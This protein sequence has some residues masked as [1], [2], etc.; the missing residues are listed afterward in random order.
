MSPEIES[1]TIIHPLGFS[2]KDVF[3]SIVEGKS[4][5]K[6]LR[7]DFLEHPVYA[8][9]FSEE[10][11][12]RLKMLC[13]FEGWNRFERLIWSAGKEVLEKSGISFNDKVLVIV[14][15]TKGGIEEIETNPSAANLN[16]HLSV[17][18]VIDKLSTEYG[19]IAGKKP[20]F[21]IVSN[22]CVSGLSAMIAGKRFLEAQDY[23][24]AVI[25][26]ADTV[27]DFVL[28]GFNSLF[29]LSDQLCRPFDKARNGI[30]LG[31]GAAAVV[32]RRNSD[33]HFNHN[34]IYLTGGA[35]TNDANHISGP[36]RTGEELAE[37]IKKAVNEADSNTFDF[38][39]AHGTATIYND[40]MESKAF[41]EAGVS[42]IPVH[43]LKQYAGHTLGAAGVME[44]VICIESLVNN[45]LIPSLGYSDCG[46][47]SKLN[48][49][50]K[51]ENREMTRF[52]KTM[53]GFG[54]CNAAVCF[55]KR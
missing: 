47:S 14:A 9:Y 26:G 36:S 32:L 31:E 39:S 44:S 20:P 54:G 28:S 16:I 55:E 15:T 30:N 41:A 5:L 34:K 35:T 51:L 13:P 53:S 29:A 22:A 40:E 48:I 24:Y 27:N 8:A 2:A 12:N 4:G 50:T 45:I 6:E 21:Y 42:D 10:Q 52:I 18:K 11:N 46:T 23:D 19:N 43:S 49:Q 17:K 38:L 7:K 25:I 33:N 37:A 1:Y 3:D